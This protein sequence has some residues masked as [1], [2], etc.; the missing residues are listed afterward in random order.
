MDKKDT[1]LLKNSLKDRIVFN[2]IDSQLLDL[3]D[4]LKEMFNEKEYK[5]TIQ[6]LEDIYNRFI[7][8]VKDLEKENTFFFLKKE[9]RLFKNLHLIDKNLLRKVPYI[10]FYKKESKSLYEDSNFLGEW[11]HFLEKNKK[12]ISLKLTLTEILRKAFPLKDYDFKNIRKIKIILEKNDHKKS[13]LKILESNKKYPILE[14]GGVEKVAIDILS[15]KESF[16]SLFED[17]LWRI[18]GRLLEGG[19][20]KVFIKNLCKSINK[21]NI[22]RFLDYLQYVESNEKLSW[23]SDLNEDIVRALLRLFK[24]SDPEKELKNL[25]EKRSDSF[26]GDPRFHTV[27]WHDLPEEKNIILRWKTKKSL[28]NFFHLIEYVST[29]S[30]DA[31]RMW[32]SRRKF[33]KSCLEN[34]HITGAW[35]VLG[36]KAL[37]LREK[38]RIESSS[39]GVLKSGGQLTHSVLLFQI[40]D[41]ILSEWSHTG[42]IRIWKNSSHSCPKLYE[43]EYTR[44]DVISIPIKEFVHVSSGSWIDR[45]TEFIFEQ[46]GIDINES[47]Y[48]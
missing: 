14:R 13:V 39:H 29:N 36:K 26:L 27:N 20:G 17:P 6:N 33:M 35:V 12:M 1:A 11:F 24:S 15:S 16:K 21:K 31:E 3:T 40:G 47:E 38:F 43:K 4:F 32:P 9:K 23:S 10:L 42:K 8:Q 18:K 30:P 19:I 45:L 37:V 7:L 28:E 48:R 46:T 22:K 41:L 34:G 2:K 44:D 25:I 5:L